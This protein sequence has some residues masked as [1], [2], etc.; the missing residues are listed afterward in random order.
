[1]SET[2]EGAPVAVRLSPWVGGLIAGWTAVVA[3]FGVATVAHERRQTDALA[4]LM[5]RNEARVEFDAAL[6]FHEGS[7][8]QGGIWVASGDHPSFSAGAEA[9]PVE[10]SLIRGELISPEGD[11]SSRPWK[12]EAL[13]ALATGR[14]ELV[15]RD[16]ATGDGTL[17]IVRWGRAL[18]RHLLPA[19]S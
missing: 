16:R 13:R 18:R 7:A 15:S 9:L 12:N 4:L 5:A 1:M 3:G 11:E 17:A 19:P 2:P 8:Q 14:H 10:G 6:L